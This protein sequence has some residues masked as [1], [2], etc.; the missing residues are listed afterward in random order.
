MDMFFAYRCVLFCTVC[1]IFVFA[2]FDTEILVTSCADAVSWLQLSIVFDILLSIC[3][4]YLGYFSVF[5]GM[6]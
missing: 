4:I 6:H 1:V 5:H 3:L 2:S